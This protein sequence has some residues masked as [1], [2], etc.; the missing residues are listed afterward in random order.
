M[1]KEIFIMLTPN[2]IF[3][4]TPDE[5]TESELKAAIEPLK[6]WLIR[7]VKI[8]NRVSKNAKSAD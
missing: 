5:K 4:F 6:T 7:F 1:K 3:L 2:K 8:L